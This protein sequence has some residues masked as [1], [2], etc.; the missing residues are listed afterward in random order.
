MLVQVR[1]TQ[2]QRPQAA[3]HNRLRT[4]TMPRRRAPLWVLLLAAVLIA[5]AAPADAIRVVTYNILNFPGSTGAEREDDFRTVTGELDA[6]VLVVQE[7]LSA[8]GVEQFLN[9]V[10]NYG[11]PGAYAAVPF[12]DGPDTDN[13]LFYRT[14]T[15]EF[16]STQQLHTALRDISEYVVRPVG[17]ASDDAALRIYSLHLK[18]GSTSSDQSKRLA[19]ASVLRDHTNSFEPGRH[20][21]AAG[22]LNIRAS[23]EAAYQRL[24]GSE[25]NDNGRFKDPIGAPGNWHDNAGFAAI[26]TQSPRTASFGGGATGGMD[27]RFDQILISYALDDGEGLDYIGGSYVAFGND[28]YHFNIAINEGTN[29]AVGPVVADAIHEAADHLPVYADFQVPAR[30]DAPLALD[31]GEFIVGAYAALPLTIANSA[32]PPADELNYE[33]G[34]PSGFSA[35][36]GPFELEPGDEASH[37]VAMDTTVP[38]ANAGTLALSSDDVDHPLWNVSVTGSVL[39]HASPSLN[40]TVTVVRE[41]LDFGEHSVGSFEAQ[42]LEV[43]NL[44][45]SAL[46]ALLE[47]NAAEVNGGGGRFDFAGGFSAQTVGASAAAYVIEFDDAGAAED[48]LYAAELRLHTRDDPS[49]PGWTDLDTLVVSLRAYVRSGTSVPD[50]EPTGFALSLGSANPFGSE[51]E[52]VLTTTERGHARVRIH[53]VS[54][55]LVRTLLAADLPAGPHRLRWDGADDDGRPCASGVYLARADSGRRVASRKLVLLR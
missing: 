10:L 11:S 14:S 39:G 38:A 7:M 55:R 17:Y 47:V 24:V 48:S 27:D 16:V 5:A 8:S 36:S 43:H 4:G 18:A 22:D 28:G 25:A 35:A 20:F 12:V 32:T 26:H 6:D 37:D 41:T 40:G 49:V 9:N 46:Q 29:Y 3:G 50:G 44:G 42:D 30:I 31:F 54:G 52:L 23:T 45:Y 15:I 1:P 33:I 2:G 13:A 21:V 34:A 53:D 51:V 19:E